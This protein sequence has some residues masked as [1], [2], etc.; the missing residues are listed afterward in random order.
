MAIEGVAGKPDEF[1]FVEAQ[2]AD[3]LQLLAE[4][5][6]VD[7]GRRGGAGVERLMSENEA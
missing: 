4:F 3:L 6:D 5:V 1:G 7:D 2:A